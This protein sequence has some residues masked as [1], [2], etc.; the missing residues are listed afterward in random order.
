VKKYRWIGTLV[1][2]VF[3]SSCALIPGMSPPAPEQSWPGGRKT[4]VNHGSAVVVDHPR[5]DMALFFPPELGEL[6]RGV[7]VST[8]A[9]PNGFLIEIADPQGRFLPGIYLNFDTEHPMVRVS[10]DLHPAQ[11][12]EVVRSVSDFNPY[13]VKSEYLG[14]VRRD[15]LSLF[16]TEEFPH[17]NGIN[18]LMP[19]E[20]L[21][22]SSQDVDVYQTR[23]T[24]SLMVAPTGSLE[25]HTSELSSGWVAI[26]TSLPDLALANLTP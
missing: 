6:A 18:I 12:G 21:L 22:V 13:E 1:A 10:A 19:Q 24:L 9:T 2:L 11:A 5:Q 15:A 25:N 8:V 16:I 3:L 23:G 26:S 20:L 4:I 7:V 17:M 14:S